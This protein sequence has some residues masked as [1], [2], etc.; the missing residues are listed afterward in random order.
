M[1]LVA[2]VVVVSVL[3]TGPKG[4]GFKPGRGDGLLRAIMIR[5]TASFGWE[6]Q[7]KATS[8]KILRHVKISWRISDTDMQHS[9]SFF[10]YSYTLPDISASSIARKL[11]WTSQECSPKW[12]HHH[13][14]GS[15]RSHITYGIN[16]RPVGGRGS[17]TAHPIDMISQPMIS[18]RF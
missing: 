14:H 5:S 17:G 10:H 6:V 2:S 8:R 13:H 12:H 4:R 3:A 18:F 7:P 11:W 16:N 15:S 9:R 1:W